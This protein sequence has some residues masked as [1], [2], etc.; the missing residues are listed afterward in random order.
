MEILKQRSTG[1][2]TVPI[3]LSNLLAD[4]STHPLG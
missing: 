2:E 3:N 1:K 4:A